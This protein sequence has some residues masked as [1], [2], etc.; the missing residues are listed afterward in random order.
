MKIPRTLHKINRTRL[1]ERLR[2]DNN[3]PER[4]IIVLQGGKTLN[5]Y[6]TDTEPVFRQES[7]F[8]WTFGVGEPDYYGA[9]DLTTGRSYLFAPKLPDS[10]SIWMGKLYTL[11]DHLNRY[12]VDAVY[13]TEQICQVLS[14]LKPQVL[15]TLKGLNTDSNLETFEAR[16]D[17]IDKFKI[18]NSLLHPHM[19]ELRVFKTPQELDVIR[20]TNKIS[21]DAHV[22]VMKSIRPGMTEYQLESIF[23]HHCYFNGGARHV[24][25][26]CICASGTNGGVLHYGHAAAPNSKTVHDGDMCSFD[27]G[28]EYYRYS[29]DITCS[30]PANGIFTPDQRII[31]EAVLKA[32]RTVMN[33]VKPGVSWRDMHLLAEKT[34]LEQMLKHG[35]LQ[36]DIDEMMKARLG[37]IFMPHGLGHLLGID[38]HDVGGYLFQCPPRS[39]EP[40]LRQLRTARILE[41]DM[42]LTI[43]PGI[44]F[45]DALLEQARNDPELSKFIV[46]PVIDRF[47][48]FGGV[49]IEDD[50][51]ITA[52]G[53]ELLTKVPRTVDEIEAIMAEGRKREIEFPQ[54]T[55]LANYK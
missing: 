33:A 26:T 5:N 27:M 32:N 37:Y 1:V 23:L 15:L 4:S 6:D 48:S 42:V 36:G 53:C 10:Y 3:I 49:R 55:L 30:F 12:N 16:F 22:E 2:S 50:V 47:R 24:S 11:N 19:A 28:C 54:K 38:V 46:W 14:G 25:Y 39:T 41:K 17:G 34:Q 29:S 9:I 44:Y 45:V 21:S 43:E 31:Y 35:L 8:H 51:V 13:Y 20:Y 7:Y 52:D 40:G 18:N